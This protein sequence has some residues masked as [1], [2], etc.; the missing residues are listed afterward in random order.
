[1]DRQA[2]LAQRRAAVEASYTQDAPGYDDEYDPATPVHRAFVARLVDLCPAGGVVLD[3]P[4]GTG[5]YFGIVLAAGRTAVGADQSTGM[6]EA[7][8]AKHPE[9]RLEHVGLQ[10]LAFD[11]EFD[12]VMT[13]DSMEHVPPEEWPIVVAN[14]R[15][16]LRP[17]G[18]LYLTV[19]EIDPAQ[20]DGAFAD[21]RAEG[22]PA[23]RGEVTTGDTGG[24]HFY[25]GRDRAKA[26]L[27]EA[28]FEIVDDADEPLDGYAYWHILVT[29]AR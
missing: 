12:G 15:R 10:E 28:G 23:V 26:W 13:V 21:A 19:E 1:M 14:L 24:Y 8:R 16:A 20:I 18:H 17:G 27:A 22:L 9:V 6:L 5:P 11:R 4:C 25:P 29:A 2:W 7:A 3:V